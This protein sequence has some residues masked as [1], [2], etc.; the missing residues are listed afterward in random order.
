[1]KLKSLSYIENIVILIARTNVRTLSLI[2]CL[3]N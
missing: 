1:M 2:E 3:E